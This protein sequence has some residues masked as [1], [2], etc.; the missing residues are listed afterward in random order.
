MRILLAVGV[1][2]VRVL[3]VGV[4]AVGVTAL[5]GITNSDRKFERDR[6][7]EPLARQWSAQQPV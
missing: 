3:A 6:R 1:L 7:I 4:L 2:A 5:F